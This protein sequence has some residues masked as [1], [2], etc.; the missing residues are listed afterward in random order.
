[1]TRIDLFFN[2]HFLDLICKI[3][4]TVELTTFDGVSSQRSQGDFFGEGALLDSN[5]KRSATVRCVT[6]VHVIEINRQDFEKY[7]Q[8]SNLSWDIKEQDNVRKKNR[9]KTILRLQKELREIHLKKGEYLFRSGEKADALYILEKGRADCLVQDNRVFVVRPGD[10]C[11]EHSLIMGRPRNSSIV[12]VSDTCI[13]QQMKAD[14]FYELYKTISPMNRTSLRE[15][16]LRREYQKALVS[17]TGKDFPSIDDLRVV[18]DAT[19][20]ENHGY[21]TIDDVRGL[22][23]SFDRTLSEEE[24]REILRSIDLDESGKITFEKF[25]IIFG[26]DDK[27][28]MPL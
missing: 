6:P 19:D 20:K 9:V 8:T 21:L 1:M 14:D 26:M 17:K 22:L 5:K 18:Y 3:K 24:I 11:G 27:R 4:G 16:C 28:N 23:Q 7:A 13:A 25:R 2:A 15:I 10:I 12:C